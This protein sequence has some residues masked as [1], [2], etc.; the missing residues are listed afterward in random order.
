MAMDTL[1]SRER[2][3]SLVV[4]HNGSFEFRVG[5]GI[6]GRNK[7]DRGLRRSDYFTWTEVTVGSNN[8]GKAQ[9]SPFCTDYLPGCAT[10]G[11]GATAMGFYNMQQGEAPYTK[12]LA[13]HYAMSDNYH[14]P[15]NG[16]DRL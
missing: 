7:S 2:G 9:P 11:E 6:R 3:G 12:Y 8:N 5:G 13:D 16:W 4:E 10:T 14:Q 15:V 1:A